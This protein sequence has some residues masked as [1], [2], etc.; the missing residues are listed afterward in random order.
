[1]TDI[2]QMS[3]MQARSQLHRMGASSEGG[4]KLQFPEWSAGS[5][6]NNWQVA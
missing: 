1:M 2:G 3:A 6:L 4:R 5:G